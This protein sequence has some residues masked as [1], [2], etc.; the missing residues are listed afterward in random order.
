FDRI[1]FSD[2][3]LPQDSDQVPLEK[4][5]HFIED[6]LCLLTIDRSLCCSSEL[7]SLIGNSWSDQIFSDVIK[8]YFESRMPRV[9]SQFEQFADVLGEGHQ[10]ESFMKSIG[11]IE[12][13]SSV[14]HEYTNNIKEHFS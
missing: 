11:M 8:F 7:I 14:F 4:L 9:E 3:A 5:K 12:Q 10:L 6:V 2:S 13:A 1:K